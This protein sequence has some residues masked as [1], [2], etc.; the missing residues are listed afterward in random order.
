VSSPAGSAIL[1]LHELECPACLRQVQAILGSCAGVTDVKTDPDSRLLTARG[2]FRTR[3]LVVSFGRHGFT[4]RVLGISREA[5]ILTIAGPADGAVSFGAGQ[6]P[7][8]RQAEGEAK[9]QTGPGKLCV[10]HAGPVRELP[11][12][13]CQVCC[14]AIPGV[15]G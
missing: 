13:S 7:V 14:G 1:H 9:A 4:A 2:R 15:E 5:S 6:A 8:N 10:V 11:A 3:E 12:A